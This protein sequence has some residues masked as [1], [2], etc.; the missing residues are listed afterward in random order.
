MTSDVRDSL[1]EIRLQARLYPK[2]IVVP[3]P[4]RIAARDVVR[5]RMLGFEQR[6][7]VREAK[8]ALKKRGGPPPQMELYP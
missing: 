3:K 4:P 1:A 6:Q 7:A 2:T 5:A 8:R